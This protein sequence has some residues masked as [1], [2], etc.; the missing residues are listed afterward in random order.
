MAFFDVIQKKRRLIIVSQ[1]GSG[2]QVSLVT[3]RICIA[4]LNIKQVRAIRWGLY[5][6]RVI[7]MPPMQ[8]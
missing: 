3:W 8:V 2:R 6:K 4:L 5:D 1:L 7:N